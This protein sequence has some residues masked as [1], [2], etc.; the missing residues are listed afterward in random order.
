MFNNF[1][2][3]FQIRQ[4]AGWDELLGTQN[5]AKPFISMQLLKSIINLD[6]DIIRCLSS[7]LHLSVELRGLLNGNHAL[8]KEE[9]ARK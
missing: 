7:H 2:I 6:L 3:K 4:C 5:L 9:R 8:T 1:V